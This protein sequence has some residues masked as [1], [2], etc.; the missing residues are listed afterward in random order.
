[1]APIAILVK[2]TPTYI[3]MSTVASNNQSAFTTNYTGIVRSHFTAY[4]QTILGSNDVS[5]HTL[6]LN[7]IRVEHYCKA[8]ISKRL[9]R[10]IPFLTSTRD[11]LKEKRNPL[12]F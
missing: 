1:M 3:M 8:L 2:L 5:I 9:C 10:Q 7:P 4:E 6:V 11:P 12:L